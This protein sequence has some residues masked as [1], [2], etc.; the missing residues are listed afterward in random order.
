MLLRLRST[1]RNLCSG[2]QETCATRQCGA[3]T[4]GVFCR[5]QLQIRGRVS[6]SNRHQRTLACAPTRPTQPCP[7]TH[8]L[9]AW[10]RSTRQRAAAHHVGRR[11][12]RCFT[13]NRTLGKRGR[14]ARAS[15]SRYAD[16]ALSCRA[17]A[18]SCRTAAQ[19]RVRMPMLAL[20]L[21]AGLE[22]LR[23]PP[24]SITHREATRPQRSPPSRL[25]QWP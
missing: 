4:C 8:P 13:E 22:G 2:E 21:A 6:S 5:A 25:R 16:S 11:Y 9:P 19:W 15:R 3:C 20:T 14:C 1:Q 23:P 12:C 24:R 17:R 7:Q 18:A 10:R